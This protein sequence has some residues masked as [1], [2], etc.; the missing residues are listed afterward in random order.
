MCFIRLANATRLKSITKKRLSSQLK[1]ATEKGKHHVM[2]TLVLCFIRLA[3]TTRLKSI[4]K[5]RLSSELK[6][7]TEKGKHHLMET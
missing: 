2:E 6:L 4:T 5:K 7:A 1:L 3:T